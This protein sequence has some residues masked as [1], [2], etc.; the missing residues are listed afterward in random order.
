MEKLHEEYKRLKREYNNLV[1][2]PK[3]DDEIQIAGLKGSE[4]DSLRINE[5]NEKQPFGPREEKNKN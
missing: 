2:L 5:L 4:L 3:S 1:E